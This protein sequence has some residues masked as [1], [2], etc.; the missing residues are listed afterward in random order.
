MAKKKATVLED[1]FPGCKVTIRPNGEDVIWIQ[2]ARGHGFRISAGAGPAGLRV[3]AGRFVGGNPISIA[4]NE[5]KDSEVF[6]GPDMAEVSM[7]QYNLDE[8]SQAFKRWYHD[9]ENN[10]HPDNLDGPTDQ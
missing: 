5:A 9:P 7:C 4:G 3:T 1:L 8:R 6:S 10:Q 2:D